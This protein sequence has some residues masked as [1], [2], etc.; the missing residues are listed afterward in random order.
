MKATVEGEERKRRKRRKK[1]KSRRKRRGDRKGRR[2]EYRSRD[3]PSIWWRLMWKE[4][5]VD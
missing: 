1:K 2:G 5:E 3:G 4:G